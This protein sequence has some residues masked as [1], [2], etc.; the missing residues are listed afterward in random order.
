MCGGPE[1]AAFFEVLSTLVFEFSGLEVFVV[2]LASTGGF[3]LVSARILRIWSSF[4]SQF[5]SLASTEG[6]VTPFFRKGI[7]RV[8]L[9]NPVIVMKLVSSNCG[10]G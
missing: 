6:D 4:A 7:F 3:M 8:T 1:G 9:T 10:M 2:C 5:I